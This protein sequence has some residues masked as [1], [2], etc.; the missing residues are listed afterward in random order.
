MKQACQ[1]KPVFTAAS[2]DIWKHCNFHI[3][4]TGQS[5]GRQRIVCYLRAQGR[6]FGTPKI[7]F[8]AEL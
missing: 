3:E 5:P 7:G 8:P 1:A 2:L 4:G 6:L